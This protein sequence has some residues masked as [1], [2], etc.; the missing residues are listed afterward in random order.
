MMILAAGE[1]LARKVKS[2]SSTTAL[3]AS[4]QNNKLLEE[5]EKG[6]KSSGD[7]PFVHAP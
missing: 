7:Q 2:W 4:L 5:R 1:D 3:S 6:G